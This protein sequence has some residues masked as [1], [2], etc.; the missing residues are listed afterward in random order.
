ML[1]LY[2]P[3]NADSLL[4]PRRDAVAVILMNLYVLATALRTNHPLP[5]HLPSAA[6]ARQKLLDCMERVE[7]RDAGSDVDVERSTG[8]RWADV[9]RYAY[10]AALTDIVA[11]VQT[12]Q[13]FTK[14][15]T[16]EL[17]FGAENGS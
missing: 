16:G 8:R 11:E 9:Y 5:H 14:E 6:A 13:H 15:V 1:H 17:G 7:H 12:L 10:S 2:P 3:P 4:Q